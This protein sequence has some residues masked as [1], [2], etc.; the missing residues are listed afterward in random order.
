MPMRL[1]ILG[2]GGYGR[3]VADVAAQT[4]DYDEIRFLDDNSQTADVIGKCADF[5]S[6]LMSKPP[7]I[8][9]SATMRAACP[10]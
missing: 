5:V 4:G 3:T 2:A 6:L 9:H 7:F 8:R 1:I 10:G